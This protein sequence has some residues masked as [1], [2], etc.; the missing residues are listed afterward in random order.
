MKPS[1]QQIEA[2][3][4][5]ALELPAVERDRWLDS[6]CAGSEALRS[7]VEALLAAHFRSAGILSSIPE[8]EAGSPVASTDLD[9]HEALHLEL[10]DRYELEDVL[11]EGGMGT[12]YQARDRKHDRKVA[13]KTIH[14]DFVDHMGLSR[15]RREIQLTAA[16][17][18]PYILPLIDSGA[19]GRFLYYI[20]PCV[21]GES[22]RGRL[23]RE[24]RLPASDAVAIAVD[25]A[26][27]LE[28]AHRIG[29]VH[30][31]IK[32]ANILLDGGHGLIC[33][34]GVAKAVSEAAG[35]LRH[36]AITGTGRA[37]GTPAYMAPEQFLGDATPRSDVYALGA[38]LFEAITG[39]QW[40]LAGHSDPD[41]SQ[42]D[43]E[44]QP[45]LQKA[46]RLRPEDRWPDAG[47]FRQGLL[48]W[49]THPGGQAFPVSTP[50]LVTRIRRLL[51]GA[52]QPEAGRKSIAVLPL[53]NLSRDEDTEVFADGITE[54]I[55]A[56]L[57]RIRDL[58][59]ISRT[60]IMRYK[61]VDRP[62][63]QIG[64]ELGVA[65]LLEGSVRR[66]GDRLRIVSQ[67]FDAESEEC[68]WAETFDRDLTDIFAVQSEVAQRIADSLEATISPAELSMIQR[69]P[70]D[71]VEAHK[72][73]LRGR[74]LWNRRT[75][76]GL[77][78]AA[79]AF[80]RAIELDPEYAPA[81]AGLAD[82]RLLLGA[83]GYMPELRAVAEAKASI[84]AALEKDERLAEAHASLGQV[85]RT[86]RNWAEEE[87][88][89]RR[90]IE[91]NPNYATAHQWYS[92]LLAALGRHEEAAREIGIA[93]DLDPLSSAIG[94]TAGSLMC[95]N[96]DF[97]RAIEQFHRT[98]ELDPDYFSP[99]AWL[100]NAYGALGQKEGAMRA[101][102][103]V[104]EIRGDLQHSRLFLAIV[105][106]FLGEA[107]EALPLVQKLEEVGG[108]PVSI[109]IVYAQLGDADRAFQ[110]LNSALDD[111]SWCMFLL[112]RN[113]LFYVKSG[114]WFDPIRDDPRFEGLLLRM[115]L[116]DPVTPPAAPPP[117]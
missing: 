1:R 6:A 30:R 18:H 73:Y 104:A 64:Q 21:D 48:A 77:E 5:A 32:P 117:D 16:L 36:E 53:K 110:I 112:L 113:L 94:V 106:A 40:P 92:T 15:F 67:L 22:L 14:P 26:E 19:A 82:T 72:L 11:G 28:H 47:S 105:Y 83:Y 89:Y 66:S 86:E 88:S 90:A 9:P 20:M 76:D 78:R 45:I 44:L 27:G 42:V 7:E 65:S 63:K 29:I 13:I 108:D 43:P 12:V 23:A 109:G 99:H 91:L 97:E 25:V 3:F 100:I 35:G 93:Q 69:R 81:H 51:F 17:R 50:G 111:D 116:A 10:G 61:V 33:D 96:R 38:V 39:S 2:L 95:L 85:Y 102:E 70:T 41:W 34:F 62:L 103:K 60:S 74:Y 56:H 115:N 8:A 58:K 31:D 79:R 114:F 80:T 107:E 4:E 84:E 55:I 101:Y 24:G 75:G 54:D 71:N 52:A 68:R 59:V 46:L 49:Q 37:I 57:S 87:E 98:L